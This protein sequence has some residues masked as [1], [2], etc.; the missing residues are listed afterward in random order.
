MTRND[1]TAQVK[2]QTTLCLTKW[3]EGGDLCL[4]DAS[5]GCNNDAE[6]NLL[7]LSTAYIKVHILYVHPW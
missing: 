2:T 6:C 7:F 1:C 3:S 4:T 5:A